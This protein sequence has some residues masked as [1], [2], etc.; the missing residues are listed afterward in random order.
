[1]NARRVACRIAALLALAAPAQAQIFRA[2]LEST[3]SD[4]NPC[5][6]QQ[7]CRLLPA[8]L[9]AV[10]DGGEVWMLD[11]ANYNA[12]QV[13]VTKS[14][15]ILA[16]PGAL[17]SLVATGGGDAIFINTPGV[18]VALRNL[19]IVHLTSSANGVNFSQGAELHVSGC[20]ISGM[21]TRGIFASAAGGKATIRDTIL[22]DNTLYGVHFAGGIT[23]AVDRVQVRNNATGILA[24]T[25]QVTI[26]NSVIV[27]NST[28]VNAFAN[29]GQPRIAIESSVLSG[30]GTGLHASS[31]Q[32]GDLADVQVSRSILA[33]NTASAIDAVQGAAGTVTIVAGANTITDNAYGFNGSAAATVYT[34]GTNT[35]AFNGTDVINVSLTALA[36]Q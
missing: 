26:A 24:T 4:A 13:D 22:R 16:V 28:G 35:L 23:A 3:G 18:K 1:M 29:A 33:N 17:G 12:A 8:A 11:S 21:Q 9:A 30:N 10:A 5:T 14:V 31:A 19:V 36:G 27:G 32:V 25:S 6:L 20:E 2:Y 34:R 15:T 7:P